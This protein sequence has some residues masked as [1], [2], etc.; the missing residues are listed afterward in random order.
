MALREVHNSEELQKACDTA[1]AGDEIV[2]HGGLYDRPAKLAGKHG[3]AAQ[4]IVIR[5]TPGTQWISGG[6][7][8]D[9]YWG[10]GEPASNA[11]FKP[12]IHD[13]ALLVIDKCAHVAVEG[14]RV[15]DCWPS[16]LFIKDSTHITVRKCDWRHATYAIFAKGAKTSHLL[17]EDNVWHQDDSCG[18]LL[19]AT[20]NWKRT[21]GGEGSDG[22]QRYFNGAFLSSKGIRGSV[23]VRRNLISDA[24]NGIRLKA[25]D[26]PP[27]DLAAINADVHIYG[28]E[29]VRIRDNPVEPEVSAYNWHVRHNRI[30]DCHS[31]F[32]FDGV[33]GGYWYF[34]GNTGDFET[35][36]GQRDVH[37]HTMGRVLKLSYQVAPRDPASERVPVHPWYV[38]NNSWH[39]RCPL[40]GGAS[41]VNTATGEGPDFT[42]HLAFLNNAFQW[43]AKATGSDP[44]LCE[45]IEMVRNF[46]A[47]RSAHT[48][49]DH[50]VCDRPDYIENMQ[51]LGNEANG[52]ASDKPIFAPRAG[53]RFNFELATDSDALRTGWV[54]KVAHA[55]GEAELRPQA[56]RTINCGARQEYGLLSV[57][58]LEAQADRLLREILPPPA[59]V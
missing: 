8:P 30:A 45:S 59:I 32:S 51:A 11:P 33:T 56:D 35:R 52:C 42:A 28:N 36:Q 1:Q 53:G 5:G 38:F 3:T 10:Q 20:Y 54:G 48:R 7:R 44:W 41:P 13:F 9:P 18:H 19:W 26:W 2:I 29:F 55:G 43:C 21:H 37:G 39:L 17:L 15:K 25:G 50:T 12:G 31:W 23:V 16:I 40:I 4:R 46:D 57:P 22:L 47:Q 14:L 6:Q 24:Y 49:F 27:A 58:E 34:Y